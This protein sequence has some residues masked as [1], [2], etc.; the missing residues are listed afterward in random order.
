MGPTGRGQTAQP[1][2]GPALQLALW[3]QAQ[4][5]ARRALHEPPGATPEPVLLAPSRAQ[6][7]RRQA[8]SSQVLRQRTRARGSVRRPVPP[9]R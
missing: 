5:Q 3:A 1:L 9:E 8:P 2:L 7:Q 4:L 6:V